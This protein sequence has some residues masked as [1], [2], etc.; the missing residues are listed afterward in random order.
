VGCCLKNR[1]L[2]EKCVRASANP[3]S[4]ASVKCLPKR[5]QPIFAVII[6]AISLWIAIDTER[7]NRRLVAE[8]AWPF[9]QIYTSEVAALGSRC[10]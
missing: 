8:A 1:E 4:P 7:T 6:A 9:V 10:H 2:T 5:A 3:D